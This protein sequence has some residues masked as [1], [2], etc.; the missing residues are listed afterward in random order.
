MSKL[1]DMDERENIRNQIRAARRR[2]KPVFINT[3]SAVIQRKALNLD[4]WRE[5]RN[6]C[7]YL[8]MPAEVQTG[9]IIEACCAAKKQLFVPAYLKTKRN[10]VPALFDPDDET[11]LGKFNVLEPA[12]PKWIQAEKIDLVFVPGL[13]FDRHGGRLGHGGGYYD[14]ILS[15]ESLRPAFK[16]G[17][18]FE[19]QMFEK[20]PMRANDVR[21]DI[22]IT[23][24]GVCRCLH[25]T[26][27]RGIFHRQK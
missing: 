8:A 2:L 15:R 14:D 6:I 9:L 16:A 26:D 18:A 27:Q 5:S 7:C 19:F 20:V 23:E 1:Q 12:A 22:V 25:P 10:Y 3:A 17:L 4:K 11:Q 21:M 13:A 24:A